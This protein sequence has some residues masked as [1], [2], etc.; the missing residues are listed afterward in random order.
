MVWNFGSKYKASS[1][2]HI[3]VGSTGQERV[4]IL[5]AAVLQVVGTQKNGKGEQYPAP[6]MED[7]GE[8]N[9]A[10]VKERGVCK[11][12]TI[13]LV[14]MLYSLG[15]L[16][17][18]ITGLASPDLFISKTAQLFTAAGVSSAS[19]DYV[20][21]ISDYKVMVRYTFVPAFLLI[22]AG[23]LLLV[24]QKGTCEEGGGLQQSQQ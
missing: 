24:K 8:D 18:L 17:V 10:W 5:A 22:T 20:F 14:S 2:E 3:Q 16:A 19:S 15:L 23:K 21:D 12:T 11:M 9:S 13:A 1:V 7:L 4:P 6:A